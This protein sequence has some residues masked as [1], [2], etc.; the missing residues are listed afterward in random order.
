MSK[1]LYNRLVVLLENNPELRENKHACLTRI[2]QHDLINKVGG[3]PYFS[4]SVTQAFE[5][6][7][8]GKVSNPDSV[9]RLWRLVQENNPHLQGYNWKANKKNGA[10]EKVKEDLLELK[11]QEDIIRDYSSK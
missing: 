7:K 11:R 9:L 1:L 4:L 6:I 5:Y 10:E 8:D 2:W 3:L